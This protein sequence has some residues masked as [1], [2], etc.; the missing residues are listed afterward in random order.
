[1]AAAGTGP[2]DTIDRLQAAYDDQPGADFHWSLL[3]FARR[4]RGPRTAVAFRQAPTW[5]IRGRGKNSA[6]IALESPRFR[7]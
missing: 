3:C 5:S 6:A 7:D 1:M 2:L 4:E